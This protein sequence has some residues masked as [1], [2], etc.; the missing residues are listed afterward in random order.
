MGGLLKKISILA[1]VA[2]ASVAWGQRLPSFGSVT[3]ET[4]LVPVAALH[5]IPQPCAKADEPFDIDD[6][7]GPF[8]RFV[9]RVSQKVDRVTVHVPRHRTGLKPC[10]LSVGEKFKLFVDDS[11]D[12]V[13]FIGAAWG[14]GIDQATNSDPRYGQGFA[15]YSKRYGAELADNATGSF[16]GI[17]VYPTIFHQDPRYYRLGHGTTSERLGHALR[18]R[19]AAVSDSGKRVPNYPEWFSVIS[20]KLVSNL[21]HPDN[22]RGFGPTAERVGFT[23]A[24][25]MAW[26][27]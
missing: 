14:A 13:N 19:F 4:A 3:P 21:Y 17:F 22:P 10:S 7:D 24:N 25:D 27:V 5:P 2:F 11:V 26:D 18:H 15:G 23:V 1:L 12:P 6:Y 9:A 20:T 16:F 8:N